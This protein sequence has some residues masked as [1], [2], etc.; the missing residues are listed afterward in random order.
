MSSPAFVTKPR[1][2]ADLIA[3]P[4][5]S[6]AMA[7]FAASPLGASRAFLRPHVVA[8]ARFA[9]SRPRAPFPL[10]ARLLASSSS[11]SSGG[12]FRSR[13]PTPAPRRRAA[14]RSSS[15]PRSSPP[16]TPRRYG[17]ALLASASFGYYA[18][19]TKS[20]GARP[21]CARCWPARP[22]Q[23]RRPLPPGPHFSTIQT[24]VVS[25]AT[26]LLLLGADLRVVFRSTRRLSAHLSAPSPPPGVS[27]LRP[28]VSA[29]L[30][31]ASAQPRT[32]TDGK[33]PPRSRRR[34]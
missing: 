15:P 26:P 25:L 7:T 9:P 24:T 32:A 5:P 22:G 30:C 27:R 1:P 2:S 4:Q 34:T 13:V 3:A 23:R 10:P 11:S 14:A 21:R 16:R 31:T 18:N 19:R 28:H 17:T 8:S 29:Q 6:R 12:L 20:A 33:S